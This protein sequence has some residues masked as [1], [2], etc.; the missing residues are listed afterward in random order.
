MIAMGLA[1][2]ARNAGAQSVPGD[3]KIHGIT[4]DSRKVAPG[5]LFAALR[6]ENADG[7]DFV[8]RAVGSGA[9]AVLVSHRLDTDVP[10]VVV[11]DVLVAL[12][13]IGAAWR[14]LLDPVVVAITGSNGKTTTKELL[15]NILGLDAFVLT[16]TG[17]F[18]NE[19]GLPLTLFDLDE[20]HDIAVL[21]MGASR[22]GDISYLAD[23]ASPDIGLVTNVGPAHLQG[24]GDEAGVARAKGELY[25]ALPGDGCAV[26]NADEPWLDLWLEMNT[27]SNRLLF[28][29]GEGCDVRARISGSGHRVICPGGE[30]DL[31]LNLPGEHNVQ[32]ALAATAVACA[33]EI[34]PEQIRRG[35]EATR[36]VP[37]RLNL[38]HT[39]GGWVVIDDTYNAN[40]ASLYAALQ[41]LANQGGEA[42]L[43]L[44]DM[45]ELGSASRKM[46]AEMGDAALS[47]GVRRL[48]AVG[49]AAAST[50]DAFGAGAR[51][52]EHHDELIV[53]LCDELHAG[54]T[55]LVKGSR[56]M[57]MER[58]VRAIS[59]SD[60]MREAS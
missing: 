24:F 4:T 11:D 46:H 54:V 31:Q 33:I 22:A 57:G 14:N 30:F 26:I 48:F 40:P 19:L 16:T 32:N 56:S 17:N 47:L 39:P 45:K 25:A 12:G 43:V 35:L 53:A 59:G 18:N 6:G 50:V 44:G 60:G 10:Q 28:G 52:F 3:V 7:H 38:V 51:H 34:P 36:P 20:A 5:M 2:V 15:G 49:E 21:E 29:S 55:C 41:V 8:D 23:I 42:W 27:A 9:A 37:G 13:R 58:V 1:D